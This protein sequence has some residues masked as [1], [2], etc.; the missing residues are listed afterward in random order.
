MYIKN[1]AI[2]FSYDWPYWLNFASYG[3][4]PVTTEHSYCIVLAVD[5]I[6]IVTS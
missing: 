4:A 1:I 5:V 3:P 6:N 2:A